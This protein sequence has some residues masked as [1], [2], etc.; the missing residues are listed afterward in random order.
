MMK[1]SK[2][3]TV[4]AIALSAF[5]GSS[6]L[7]HHSGAMWDRTKIVE[8]KGTIMGFEYQVP[9]PWIRIMT[10]F[11]GK[12]QEFDIEAASVNVLHSVDVTPQTLKPGDKVTVHVHPIRDG[13][14]AG[15]LSDITLANGRFVS[16]EKAQE[17]RK[18]GGQAPG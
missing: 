4:S 8:Y 16:I 11:N 14:P 3:L 7:A 10:T 1:S 15:D 13:R 5:I 6:A 2:G 17:K 18:A 12:Q 9:H